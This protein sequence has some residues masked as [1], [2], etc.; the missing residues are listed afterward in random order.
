MMVRE[1]VDMP[2]NLGVFLFGFFDELAK[3]SFIA[4][5]IRSQIL[6][7]IPMVLSLKSKAGI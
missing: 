4:S 7:G 3:S 2:S 5:I 6:L 1:D